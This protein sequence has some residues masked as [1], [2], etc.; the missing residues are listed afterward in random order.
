MNDEHIRNGNNDNNS[1]QITPTVSSVLHSLNLR[2]VQPVNL[3]N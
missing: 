3:V 2:P 1:M